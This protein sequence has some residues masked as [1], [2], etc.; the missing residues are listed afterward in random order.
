VFDDDAI[1]RSTMM[2][3]AS[4]VEMSPQC[5]CAATPSDR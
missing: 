4:S 5:S 2:R 3:G 1:D